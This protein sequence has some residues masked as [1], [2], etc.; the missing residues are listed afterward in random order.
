MLQEVVAWVDASGTNVGQL[1]VKA[2][3]ESPNA[4]FLSD[5][6]GRGSCGMLLIGADCTEKSLLAPAYGR[7]MSDGGVFAEFAKYGDELFARA[8]SKTNSHTRGSC[9][10][11][12]S[13]VVD[14]MDASYEAVCPSFDEAGAI[15]RRIAKGDIV[16]AERDSTSRVFAFAICSHQTANF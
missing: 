7:N 5:V 2:D 6:L 1:M 15:V 8:H 9:S 10:C 4:C 16:F 12:L 13:A 3:K 11:G 14:M